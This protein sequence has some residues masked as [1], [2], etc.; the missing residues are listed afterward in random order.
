M[1]SQNADATADSQ[2]WYAPGLHFE[3]T[4]CG[5]CCSGAP[6][7]VWVDSREI[8][9]IADHLN[10]PLGE[11]LHLKCRQVGDRTSLREYPNGDCIYLDGKTRGCTIYPVR[12][13]QCRTWPFWNSHL[14]SPEAWQN[15]HALC[16][17][18]G[19][20]AFIPLKQI[21]EQ[22]AELDL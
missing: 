9:A 19:Q 8:Q 12:P 18:V 21:E 17:G 22:A 2:P 1:D 4:Q 3:C 10:V 5:N 7:F 11:I 15:V 20:G 16:P 14:A 6:G 13:K